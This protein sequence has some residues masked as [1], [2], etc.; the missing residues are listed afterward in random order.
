MFTKIIVCF[1]Y[2]G[3]MDCEVFTEWFDIFIKMVK[4]RSLLLL[5]D[6]H[7]T[8]I[9]LPVIEKAMKG[10][11]IIM[12]FPPQVTNTLQP[13]NVTCFGPLKICW[14]QLLQERVNL[15]AAKSQLSKEDFVNELCKIW[16]DGTRESNIVNR[17]SSTGEGE[18]CLKYKI[19][20]C[21]VLWQHIYN[22][23]GPYPYNHLEGFQWVPNGWKWEKK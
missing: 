2:L 6:G 22:F 3:W 1:Q 5:F 11:V 9:T 16:K 18:Q 13:L 7:M 10:R 19:L 15:F 8:H 20:W 14:E 17:F 23:N 4:D 12:K 21:R